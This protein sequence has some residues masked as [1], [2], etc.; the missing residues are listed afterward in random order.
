M[1]TVL[2]AIGTLQLIDTG[3][4]CSVRNLRILAVHCTKGCNGGKDELLHDAIVEPY[5]EMMKQLDGYHNGCNPQ[6]EWN[7]D[8]VGTRL[9]HD[10]NRSLLGEPPDACVAC[11]K[12]DCT[13]ADAKKE[14]PRA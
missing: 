1:V 12:I 2:D 8:P 7:Q 3:R 11:G 10:A 13:G 6:S 4:R 14:A 9:R 5:W